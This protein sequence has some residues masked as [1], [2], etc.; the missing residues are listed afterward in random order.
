MN[1]QE[2]YNKYVEMRK[3]AQDLHELI[4]DK[5]STYAKNV[6]NVAIFVGDEELNTY[7]IDVEIGG[8]ES[9]YK[10]W[11]GYYTLDKIYTMFDL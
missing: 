4:F 1:R 10:R 9:S 3:I 2:Q 5:V 11:Y 7:F 6:Y 8:S